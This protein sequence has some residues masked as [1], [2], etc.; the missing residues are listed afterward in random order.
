M[1]M[2]ETP[3]GGPWGEPQTWQP[4][5]A[6][7]QQP[8]SIT[9]AVRLMWI[10]A[11]LSLLGIILGFVQRDEIEKQVRESD[12]S[13]T[14][15]EVDDVVGVLLAFGVVIGLLAAGL[16]LWMASANGKGKSWARIV[17]SVLGGLNILFALIN[18]G[19]GNLPPVSVILTLL[20]L[21]LAAVVLFLLYRPD[22]NRYYDAMTPR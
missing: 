13:L 15:D 9:T 18:I 8:Q 11:G 16:W 6:A 20:N 7:E 2:P 5:T 12:S 17:A 19:A 1:N 21:V 4:T 3:A 14:A 22:S 10:G